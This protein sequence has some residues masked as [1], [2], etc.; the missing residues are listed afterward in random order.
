M[1]KCITFGT[2]NSNYKYIFIT[3]LFI[4]LYS[5][6]NGIGYD[7]NP[8][9]YINFLPVGKLSSHYLFHEIILYFVCIIVS[10]IFILYEKFFD[11]KNKKEMGKENII[12]KK[13]NSFN[14]SYIDLIKTE[15]KPKKISNFFVFFII[16]IIVFSEQYVL[17]YSMFFPSVHFWMVELYFIALI[18][19]KQFKIEIYKHQYL[20]FAIN[21]IPITLN[22]I[23]IALTFAEKDEKKGLYIKY[24]WLIFIA[25]LLYLIYSTLISFALVQ[26]KKI[27]YLKFLPVSYIVLI[28][29]ILGVIFCVSLSTIFT[30]NSCGY[31][32]ENIY[33]IKDNICKIIDRD[34]QTFFENYN[35]YFSETWKNSKEYEKRNE[36]ISSILKYICFALHKYYEMK[37]VE[38]LTPFHRI[39][40]SAIYYCGEIIYILIFKII[41][42]VND[43]NRYFKVKL[44]ID[45]FGFLFCIIAFLIY[46]EIIEINLCNLNYNLRKNIIIR[47]INNDSIHL[48]LDRNSLIDKEEEE[49]NDKES[50]ETNSC[51]LSSIYS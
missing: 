14:S 38:S 34:N 47:G 8:N 12:L 6:I 17:I 22:I 13:Q 33:E 42:I 20:A 2:W 39:I 30:F 28:Y 16:F 40:S 50:N 46:S 10:C 35:I 41:E 5:I 43:D 18:Y 32:K 21:F 3:I 45:F 49:E 4:A 51:E 31:Y 29:G 24:W 11:Y 44:S 37:I 19:V 25:V 1:V 9:Y 26:L 15:L 36:I 7:S 23:N 48:D 27:Y